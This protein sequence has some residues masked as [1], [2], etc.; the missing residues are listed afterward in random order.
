VGRSRRR[1]ATVYDDHPVRAPQDRTVNIDFLNPECGPA[2]RG[3][4]SRLGAP[5]WLRRRSLL[6]QT[7]RR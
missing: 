4:Q 6:V 7:E 3:A 1:I 2:G 5:C